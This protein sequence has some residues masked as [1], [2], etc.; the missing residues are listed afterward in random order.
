MTQVS[1]YPS[2]SC[3]DTHSPFLSWLRAGCSAGAFKAPVAIIVAHPDDE[4]IG[5]G[6]QLSK[7]RRLAIIHTTDGAPRNLLDAHRAGFAC[8]ADYA[9]ARRAELARALALCRRETEVTSS[10]WDVPDQESAFHLVQL[11]GHVTDL[12][13]SLQPAIV[14]THPYEGGHPDHDSTAFAVHT[15]LARLAAEGHP[16]PE[17]VEMTFYHNAAGSMAVG[18]FLPNTVGE[19]VTVALESGEQAFK[20][21]LLACFQ[22]QQMTLRSFQV[23]RERFRRAP[24]YDFTEPPHAGTLFYELFDWGMRGDR[25]R[26]LAGAALLQLGSPRI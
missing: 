22:T 11:T 12:L 4:V 8:S 14:L 21:E 17:L 7:L 16:A 24:A 20:R 5:A 18:A 6:A 23:D 15:A 2:P 19:E 13:R 10:S 3:A 26:D 9:A 25:W 1:C